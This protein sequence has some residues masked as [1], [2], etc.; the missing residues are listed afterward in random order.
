MCD[1][2][3]PEKENY[4]SERGEGTAGKFPLERLDSTPGGTQST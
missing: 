1:L 4:N 3:A 2:E